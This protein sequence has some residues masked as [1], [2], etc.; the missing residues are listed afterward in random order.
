MFTAGAGGRLD[1]ASGAIVGN[2]AIRLMVEG[3]AVELAPRAR[4]NAVAPTWTETPLWKNIPAAD[5]QATKER[6]SNTI[7]FKRTAEIEEVAQV[8]IF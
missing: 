6:F 8:Y 4:V 3:L 2:D 7:P 1:N 5:V